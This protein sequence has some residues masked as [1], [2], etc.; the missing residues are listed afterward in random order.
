[1]PTTI[2]YHLLLWYVGVSANVLPVGLGLWVWRWLNRPLRAIW[3]TALVS[4][5][6]TVSSVWL[7]NTG[8][9]SHG[10]NYMGPVAYAVLYALAFWP[11]IGQPL[12]RQ[13]IRLFPLVPMALAAGLFLG[14]G[15]ELFMTW[16]Y[17]VS[18]AWVLVLCLVWFR[19]QVTYRP[20]DSLRA[21]PW[22][23][24]NTALLME[25]LFSLLFNFTAQWLF[26]YNAP[27]FNVLFYG[28]TPFMNWLGA[29]LLCIGFW[30]QFQL[31]KGVD[32][33]LTT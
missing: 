8:G 4:V 3:G 1:M 26:G 23:W 7:V 2:D 25:K 32:L 14:R 22:F 5:S 16:G 9:N 27:L 13:S 31:K 33:P 30:K 29:V 10:L 21:T 12:V 20:G 19:E 15:L 11:Q 18:D 6:L 17:V 28:V 24:I